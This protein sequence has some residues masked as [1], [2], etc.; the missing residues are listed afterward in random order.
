M[1]TT[2]PDADEWKSTDKSLVAVVP[3]YDHTDPGNQTSLLRLGAYESSEEQP[4]GKGLLERLGDSDWAKSARAALEKN[5]TTHELYAGWLEYTDGDRTV[6]VKRDNRQ[7]YA[8]HSHEFIKEDKIESIGGKYRLNIGAG[9]QEVYN[10]DPIYFVEFKKQEY[11]LAGGQ[12]TWRKTEMGHNSTDSYTFGDV[13]SFFGGYKLD[14]MFGLTN[15]VYVGGKVD[16]SFAASLAVSVGF[17]VELCA[18]VKCSFVK[19]RDLIVADDV[20]TKARDSI[21]LRV[22]ESSDWTLRRE[23]TA[24]VVVAGLVGTGAAAVLAGTTA[25]APT[26]E[27]G[28]PDASSKG[29]GS[30][31]IGGMLGGSA[32]AFALGLAGAVYFALKEKQATKKSQAELKIEGSGIEL[33]HNAADG[34]TMQSELTLHG[35]HVRLRDAQGSQLEL[36]AGGNLVATA[37]GHLTLQNT[38]GS[39]TLELRKRGRVHIGAKSRTGGPVD[40]VGLLSVNNGTL[41]VR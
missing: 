12:P 1:T 37:T 11:V 27:V 33:R 26:H 35:Q 23:R 13:E 19:G 28:G 34:T 6:A 39:A 25:A 20:E 2:A 21:H 5:T 29:T 10:A 4:D 3:D 32:A 17:E 9:T 40:I 18:G 31:G 41:T 16:V 14:A 38:T 22:K 8:G 7:A 24:G 15:N 30:G 36:Q